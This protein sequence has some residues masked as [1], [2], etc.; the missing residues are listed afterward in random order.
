ME[1]TRATGWQ[2]N[3]LQ[4]LHGLAVICWLILILLGPG[5]EVSAGWLVC[6][7]P[8]YTARS[9]LPSQPQGS[10]HWRRCRGQ[11]TAGWRYARRTLRVPL[12][13][14]GLLGG[15]WLAGGCLGPGWLVGLPWLW[16]LGVQV[17]R[18]QVCQA[19]REGGATQLLPELTRRYPLSAE[20]L[21]PQDE[22]LGL[23]QPL[24]RC[25]EEQGGLPA[26][27]RLSVREVET[28]A[29]ELGLESRPPAKALPWLLRLKQLVLGHWEEA[30]DGLP[31]AEVRCPSC[32]PGAPRATI[33]GSSRPICAG[34]RVG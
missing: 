30:A 5:L 29:G 3:L 14:W 13:R 33:R 23:V 11:W 34:T 24:V 25:V 21:R 32:W 22:W 26:E 18:R 1:Y 31:S 8:V 10:R 4:R 2:A 15:C 27:T 19:S 17:R 20:D 9:K 12:L 6:P 28:L 7:S 16:C